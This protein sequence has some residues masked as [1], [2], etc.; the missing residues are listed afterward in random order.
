METKFDFK[1][2]KKEEEL[3]IDGDKDTVLVMRNRDG[4]HDFFLHL[5]P[6]KGTNK[7]FPPH[8]GTALTIAACLYNEDEDFHTLI[9]VKFEQY[10]ESYLKHVFPE[11]WS[12]QNG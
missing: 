4:E 10:A 7:D 8:I 6:F 2:F 9:G 11:E 1:N 3:P 12:K 5:P